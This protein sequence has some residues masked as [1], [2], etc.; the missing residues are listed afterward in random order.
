MHEIIIP[1]CK[2]RN[3]N[4]KRLQQF[5]RSNRKH[6]INPPQ[7]RKRKDWL[8]DLREGRVLE[9]WRDKDRA[10]K[11]LIDGLEKDGLLTPGKPGI[12]VE[13]TAGN[14]GIG[15]GL[16][17]NTR[18]YKFICVIPNSQSQEKKDM[19]KMAGA[20]LVQVP[21]KGWKFMNNYIRFSGR[22]AEEVGGVWANQF[23]N[24]NNRR[25]HFETT[26]P[27]IYAQLDGKIDAF[28]CAVGTGGT[29]VGTT[30]YLKSVNPNIKCCLTDPQG[31]AIHRFYKDGELKSEGGSITE[32]IGQGRITGN[33]EG[34]APDMNFEVDDKA[35]LD[36]CFELLSKEGL[37]V[38]MSAGLNAA[39]A[40]RVAR[41]L[42]PGHTIVTIL[43]DSG[44]RYQGKMFNREFLKEK[45]L[46]EPEFYSDDIP[47]EV[48]EAAARAMCPDG[49]LAPSA[50]APVAAPPA[51]E[52]KGAEAALP[53]VA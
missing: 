34:F 40:E 39:G 6:A 4:R 32:G 51:E 1:P 43:C 29:L 46:P 9:P 8:Q 35:A 12:V 22:L 28:S 7:K 49:T 25:A 33:L 14:T 23:D 15:L 37:C 45:E 53:P 2:P 21:P 36:S 26:G 11:F 17:C 16:V 44:T 42:G 38:G 13:G 50:A 41:E 30:Q 31:A 5:H 19:L 10:A 52:A 24:I 18:G 47:S 27:E 48:N 20:T 3:P